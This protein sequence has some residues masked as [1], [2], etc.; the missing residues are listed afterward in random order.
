VTKLTETIIDKMGISKERNEEI[1]KRLS[2]LVQVA[3]RGSYTSTSELI[4]LIADEPTF[5][6]KECV[7]IGIL[8]A[9][10]YDTDD[11]C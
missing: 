1:I 9:A 6:K 11:N 10:M 5:T 3:K 4:S 7:Y 8:L 2:E